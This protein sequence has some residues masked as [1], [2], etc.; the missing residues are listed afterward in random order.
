MVALATT[1][2]SLTY[3]FDAARWADAVACARRGEGEL[4]GR[5][6]M[7]LLQLTLLSKQRLSMQCNDRRTIWIISRSEDT[8]CK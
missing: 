5:R 4:V 1:L 3:R 2:T 7:V 8:D 6:C